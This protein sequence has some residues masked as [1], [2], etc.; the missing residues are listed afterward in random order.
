MKVAVFSD[1]HGNLPALETFMSNERD[2]DLFIFLGDAVNYGPWSNECVDLI[3]GISNVICITGNHEEAFISGT[4]PGTNEIAQAFFSTCYP[5]F[6]RKAAI[7]EYQPQHD[8]FDFR[9]VHTI[10][11]R[12]IYP[13]TALE[14]DRNYF[15]GHS[16]HQF[17][18]HANGHVLYNTGSIGQNRRFI[19]VMNYIRF[20]PDESRVEMVTQKTDIN[21]VIQEMRSRSY[22][23]ICLDYYLSKEQA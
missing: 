1:V 10:L 20:Y 11:E 8:Q 22:P 5:A 4:Y 13:D 23:A 6:N 16:H 9:F 2:A 14:L 21:Q 17:V 15:I 7:S 12:N 3:A 19:N 18:T